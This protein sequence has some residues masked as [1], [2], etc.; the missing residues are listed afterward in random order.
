MI[1]HVN[2]MLR[3]PQTS[4]FLRYLARTDLSFQDEH[5]PALNDLSKELGIGISV[6]REQLEVA[7]ALGLV[8]VRPRT[9]IRRLPYSFFP[10]VQKSLS[11]AIER[12]QSHFEAFADLRNH[13][14]ACYWEEA[15]TALLPEHM[16]ELK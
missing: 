1:I 13:L 11:Y 4:Q 5:L 9:G 16:I 10:A 14:E 8:E 7:R 12:S 6:L 15:V 2:N 3:N